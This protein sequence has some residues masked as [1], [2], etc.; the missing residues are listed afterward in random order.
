[1]I[2]AWLATKQ[3]AGAHPVVLSSSQELVILIPKHNL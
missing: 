1:M 2:A 3:T